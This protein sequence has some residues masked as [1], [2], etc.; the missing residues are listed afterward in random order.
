M[1]RAISRAL[2]AAALCFAFAAAAQQNPDTDRGLKPGLAYRLEGLDNVNLFNGN[3]N[4]T[5]PI[6]QTYTVGGSLSY[7]FKATYTTNAWETGYNETDYEPRWR[8][9]YGPTIEINSYEFPARHV[10]AGFGWMMTLGKLY[11]HPITG[12][13]YY[14][15]P[16]GGEHEISNAFGAR[17]T[18]DGTYLRLTGQTLEF[19]NGEMHTFDTQG[20][21]TRMADRFGNE[22]TVAYSEEPSPHPEGGKRTVWTVRDSNV[23]NL[24]NRVHYVYMRKGWSYYEDLWEEF[25]EP[26]YRIPHEVVDRIVLAAFDGQ[27]AEYTFNYDAPYRDLTAGAPVDSQLTTSRRC[28]PRHDSHTP[29]YVYIPILRSISMPEGV[30]YAF[31]TD[32]GDHLTCTTVQNGSISGNITDLTLPTGGRIRW[33]YQPWSLAGF[34]S[35]RDGTFSLSS[36]TTAGI[37]SRVSETGST[38]VGRAEYT[39][40]WVDTAPWSDLTRTVKTYDKDVLVHA[41][42]HYFNGCRNPAGCGDR[43]ASEYGLPFSRM[44]GSAGAGFLSTEILVPGTD[45]SL[46]KK[47]S[48]WLGYE[49][50]FPGSNTERIF[51][52]RVA[53]ERTQ[54][55]NNLYSDVTHSDYD[56]LGHYR[57]S[58]TGGDFE[59]E[60]ARSTFVKYNPNG[61]PSLTQPWILNTYAWQSTTE[62][63]LSASGARTQQTSD[64]TVCFDANGFLRSRRLHKTYRPG[65]P[66]PAF[67]GQDLLTVF[68]PDTRGNVISERHYGALDGAPSYNCGS[69][70][71]PAGETVRIDHAYSHGQLARSWYV[72]ANGAKLSW[73]AVD[74]DID[75]NTGAVSADKQFRFNSDP[76]T[77]GTVT[78]YR[79]DKLGRLTTVRTPELET[80]HT[81]SLSP[82]R[83]VTMAV[84]RQSLRNMGEG[85]VEYD[86]LGRPVREWRLMADGTTAARASQYNALGWVT[87]ATDWGASSGSATE[88]VYDAFGRPLIVKSPDVGW[89]DATKLSYEGVSR[90][91]RSSMVRTAPGSGTSTLTRAEHIEDYDRQ[92]RLIR[93]TEPPLAIDNP[94]R[95]VT[96]YYY[97]EASRLVEVCTKGSASACMQRRLFQ[98]DAHGLLRSETH[99][100]NGTTEYLAYDARGRVRHRRIGQFMVGFDYDRGERLK[101]VQ[102]FVA[103]HWRPVKQF[104][105]YGSNEAGSSNGQLREAVRFNW[106]P[107]DR[108][109]QVSETYA[110][111]ANGRVASRV[112]SDY[113][114]TAPADCRVL[115]AGTQKRRFEQ[116]FA[117]D[118][119]GKTAQ[120]GAPTNC[121]LTGCT[122][123]PPVMTSNVY[124]NGW[125]TSVNWAGGSTTLAWDDGGLVSRVSHGNGVV[126]TISVDPK[127]PSRPL[128]IATEG[129]WNMTAC[130]AP[131]FTRQPESVTIALGTATTLRAS[132]TG[133]TSASIDYAWYRTG[134]SDSAGSGTELTVQP[135]ATTD[136]W[137]VANNGCGI[138]TSQRVTVAVCNKPAITQYSPDKRITRDQTAKLSVLA[139]TGSEPRSF[140]WYEL[141]GSAEVAIPAATSSSVYVT[142]S[143]DTTYVVKVTNDCGTASRSIRVTVD[144]PATV[145]GNMSA[146]YDPAKG[147]VEIRW[148]GSTSTRGIA[149]YLIE[150]HPGDYSY[151]RPA[152]DRSYVDTNVQAGV[153]Y[154]YTVRALDLNDSYSEATP[155]DWA[156]VVALQGTIGT[157]A[158]G[159]CT[160]IQAEHV[161]ELRRAVNA[162]RVLAGLPPAWPEN[163]SLTARIQSAQLTEIR[164]ALNQARGALGAPL[165]VFSQ[166]AGPNQFIR[167]SSMVELRD[168][169]R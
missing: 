120:L 81:Y 122:S 25:E 150:R 123:V 125:L 41:T 74:R 58:V 97:D 34:P 85:G 147:G 143:G 32:R 43:Y 104:S 71:A 145:P 53:Y 83:I 165:V 101:E 121:P 102:E 5:I 42:V 54:Y 142:P 133:D 163:A 144:Q 87:S 154:V 138:T 103:D 1:I 6:G 137:V 148:G 15:A 86:V 14:V 30:Q 132:A 105:F 100:E 21:L 57:H 28:K 117:Y 107:G 115:H 36:V 75:F 76:S 4:L 110:Y 9:N 73:F 78:T 118:A 157:C 27:T 88:T 13:V 153:A 156:V 3:V 130:V 109:V 119:A 62:Q 162:L 40:G 66:S 131:T 11:T 111:D 59:R 72:D 169:V 152:T 84:D 159:Q 7:A 56:G 17:G 64:V 23:H 168:G 29:E 49:S 80:T 135:A 60:N 129:I 79:Y 99:P 158:A 149:G 89:D 50:D 106:L 10:N 92:G 151:S 128:A 77:D 126:D 55:E 139:A 146:T 69:T 48:T 155:R 166:S 18:T 37:K 124:T 160:P 8:E 70:T 91:R 116:S 112:T 108:T 2:C 45:G 141:A 98:Y 134:S 44:K 82:A 140:Q 68:V 167:A 94:T 67:D 24:V 26:K 39:L 63:V 113:H 136:Y 164:D 51:N 93:V 38:V 46:V 47:R 35:T 20:R 114:C 22:V 33:T 12:K 61:V 65:T 19:P 161:R 16:D 90:V 95:P 96:E 127:V 31:T 52:A